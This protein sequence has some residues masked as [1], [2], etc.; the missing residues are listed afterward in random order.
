MWRGLLARFA[1]LFLQ[2]RRHLAIKPG[3][4]CYPYNLAALTG[5][6]EQHQAGI[7]AAVEQIGEG[8]A[9]HIRQVGRLRG[10]TLTI[11]TGDP[12]THLS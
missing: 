2:L 6:A 5:F 1:L 4:S 12:M 3:E 7:A 8:A 11:S 9:V 10:R